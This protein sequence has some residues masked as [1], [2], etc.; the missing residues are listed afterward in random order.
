MILL[1]THAWVWWASS[2][3]R[4]SR[5]AAAAIADE[6]ERAVSAI[7]CWEVATLVRR[8]RLKLDRPAELWLRQ[9][10]GMPG[11]VPL[12]VTPEIASVAGTLG[13]DFHG[14]PADRI[15]VA[16]ALAR[17]CRIL[18]RDERLRSSARVTTIW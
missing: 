4:L 5:R 16:T 1:D 2:P 14:D 9:A 18:T 13:D 12:D 3:E 8:G 11:V 17:A 15:L 7:S 6:S 10:L